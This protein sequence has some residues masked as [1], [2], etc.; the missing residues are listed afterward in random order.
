MTVAAIRVPADMSRPVRHHRARSRADRSGP[1]WRSPRRSQGLADDP[2]HVFASMGNYIFRTDRL[3]EMPA[4]RRRGRQTPATTSAAISFPGSWTAGTPSF[5]DFADNDV[6]GAT[7]RDRGYWRDVGTLDSYYEANMDLV[8]VHPGLQPVQPANGPST[9]PHRSCRRPSSSSRR[10]AAPG[11]RW[12]PWWAPD[13]HL[14]RHGPAVGPLARRPDRERS[15]RRR[16]GHHERREHRPGCRGP[17]GDH[18][19]ER[20]R[21]GRAPGSGSTLMRDDQ[22]VHPLRRKGSS[23]SARAR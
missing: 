20:A 7:E 14:R 8:S 6:P 15:R 18:R 22:P 12:T 11:G 21:A 5:Y 3:L 4:R 16:L 2:D 10:M 23:S 19:Q 17:P 1:F 9:R 13:H